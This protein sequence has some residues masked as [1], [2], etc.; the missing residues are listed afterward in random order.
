MADQGTMPGPYV[1][2]V[3]KEGSDPMMNYVPFDHTDIGARP[4]T[5]SQVDQGGP[6]GLNH[7]GGSTGGP[8]D[9]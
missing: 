8:K 4:S 6:K 3:P 9:R 2:S 1:N 7:V 5:L